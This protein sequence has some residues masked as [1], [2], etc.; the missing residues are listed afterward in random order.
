MKDQPFQFYATQMT[1]RLTTP[2]TSGAYALMEMHHP[3]GV[4]PALHVHPRS[5]ESFYVLE[6]QY[7]FFLD[8]ESVPVHPGSAVS[9]PAG[10][11]HRYVSG[12]GGGRLL[13]M[14]PPGLEEY[15]W[16]ISKLLQKG[17][18]PMEEE[19]ALA[20]R[21]GQD[22]LDGHDHWGGHA[23]PKMEKKP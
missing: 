1:V 23:A 13:V 6:G 10:M 19:F 18:V 14:I 5:P 4:G 7:T 17:P 22:F 20:A 8:G 3:P 21:L 9:I 12:P 2:E 16:T 11:P 15:F